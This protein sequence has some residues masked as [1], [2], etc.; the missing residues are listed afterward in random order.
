MSAVPPIRREVLVPGAPEVA[1]AVFAEQIGAWWPLAELGVFHD[2]TVA[3][4]EGRIVEYS[5]AGEESV[6]GT[7][8]A[9]EP[10]S[11]L[12]FTWHPGSDPAVASRVAVAFSATEGGTLVTLVHDGW[13]SF[14]DPSAARAE[15][16]RGWP[17]VLAGFAAS[18]EE[19]EGATWVVL[20]HTAVGADGNAFA[21]PRFPEHVAFL[22]R[23][24]RA[25]YLVAAGPLEAGGGEGMTVL[26]LPGRG[27]EEEAER[28]AR[29]DGAVAHGL[30]AVE[31]RPWRVVSAVL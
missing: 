4:A 8:T 29:G 27:R 10:P 26:R 31:V 11:A 16:D 2:G 30:F 23:M 6:W 24:R 25:G 21:D 9:W 19:P 14:A 28:L 12:A 7:V 13:E 1:F 20:R 3:F 5:A 18:V 22:D 17:R 15:Y